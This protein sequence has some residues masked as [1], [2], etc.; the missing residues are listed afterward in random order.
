[1]D[2]RRERFNIRLTGIAGLNHGPGLQGRGN[3]LVE[4]GKKRNDPADKL[5]DLEMC[6]G[7]WVKEMSPGTKHSLQTGKIGQH[8]R[9]RQRCY[10]HK[11]IYVSLLCVR[12]LRVCVCG[13]SLLQKVFLRFPHSQIACASEQSQ[14]ESGGLR[15]QQFTITVL[16]VQRFSSSSLRMVHMWITANNLAVPEYRELSCWKGNA[17]VIYI[18]SVICCSLLFNQKKKKSLLGSPKRQLNIWWCGWWCRGTFKKPHTSL[19]M[20]L[21]QM[22]FFWEGKLFMSHPA[23]GIN[24]YI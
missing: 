24:H 6:V 9:K 15:C 17:V 5:G 18:I 11:K 2:C 21:P 10:I 4:N 22:P 12:S 13:Q 3:A 14:Q 16:P 1:M 8:C 19:H 20:S 7:W 23:E